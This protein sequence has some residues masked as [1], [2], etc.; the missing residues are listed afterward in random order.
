MLYPTELR[1]R[2]VLLAFCDGGSTATCR[3]YQLF[4]SR[5]GIRWLYDGPL[6]A[7]VRQTKRLTALV[8]SLATGQ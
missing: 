4:T 6:T 1:A 7:S 3:F 5:G 8:V 2:C